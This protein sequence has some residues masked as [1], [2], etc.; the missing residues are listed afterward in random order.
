MSTAIFVCIIG[1]R[2]DNQTALLHTAWQTAFARFASQAA[3]DRRNL[4]IARRTTQTTTGDCRAEV[5]K[6]VKG[7]ILI[8]ARADYP[9]SHSQCSLRSSNFL[10][11][12]F[13]SRHPFFH[14]VPV[15]GPPTLPTVSLDRTQLNVTRFLLRP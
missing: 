12:Y 6:S 13:K 11:F 5:Q 10:F 8:G 14:L 15:L 1:A 7:I 3:C 9:Q 4:P 2:A